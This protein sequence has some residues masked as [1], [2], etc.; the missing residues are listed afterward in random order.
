[1]H[2]ENMLSWDLLAHDKQ[3]NFLNTYPFVI[4]LFYISLLQVE[5]QR[6]LRGSS[7]KCLKQNSGSSRSK[8]TPP[9]GHPG[10][11]SGKTNMVDLSSEKQASMQTA[12]KTSDVNR[13]HP[14]VEQKL[15]NVPVVSKKSSHRS[16]DFFDKL[17][18]IIFSL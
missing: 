14:V 2:T 12:D 18:S 10:I 7:G 6:I 9:N 13:R 16:N 1:M 8:N 15:K 5:N 3:I 17:V 4:L 11:F